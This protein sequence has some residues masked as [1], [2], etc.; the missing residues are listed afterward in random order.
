MHLIFI[1]LD[2]TILRMMFNTNTSWKRMQLAHGQPKSAWQKTASQW[3]W[4]TQGDTHPSL[5]ACFFSWS[6]SFQG[7]LKSVPSLGRVLCSMGKRV[8]GQK[9]EGKTG[10]TKPGSRRTGLVRFFCAFCSW[11]KNVH[12]LDFKG[13]GV[14]LGCVESPPSIKSRLQRGFVG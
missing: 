12:R 10:L 2:Y 6:S 9:G 14:V 1:Y 3:E 13:G 11:C 8:A 7:N 5:I 4:S